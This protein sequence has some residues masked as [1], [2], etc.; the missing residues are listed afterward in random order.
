MELLIIFL[1]QR[2]RSASPYGRGNKT[3]RDVR[4]QKVVEKTSG[5]NWIEKWMA[6]KPWE[7][8]LMEEIHSV[9]LEVTHPYSRKSDGSVGFCP[10]SSEQNSVKVTRNNVTTR[11][12]C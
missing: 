9:P 12:F 6:A 8:R 1:S 5:W 11:V 10:F 3:P 2:P 4:H 7:N